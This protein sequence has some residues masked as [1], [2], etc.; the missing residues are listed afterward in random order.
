MN[1]KLKELFG[2]IEAEEGLKASTK[3]FLAQKTRGYTKG[4]TGR[5]PYRLGVA[6]CACVL[7]LL[8]GGHWLYFTPTAQISI[9]INPSLELGVN[10]FDQVIFV[11]SFNRDGQELADAFRIRFRNYEDAV[12]QIL[13]SEHIA[14]LLSHNEILTITVTGPDGAQSAKI[15]SGM[16]ACTAGQSNAYCYFAPQE[17]LA[18]A[19]EAGLSYGKYRAFLELQLLDPNITPDAIRGMTMREI[20]DRIERLSDGAEDNAQPNRGNGHGHHGFGNRNAGEPGGG[21]K[22]QKGNG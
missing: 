17:E 1:G 21:Q 11:D 3:A 18:G 8:V 9:D 15:L 22:E 5:H 19:H 16:E 12:Q 20:R 7:L 10:R 4:R 6:A 13:G 14:A 2:Q